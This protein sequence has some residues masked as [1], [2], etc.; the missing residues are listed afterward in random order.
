L[1][2]LEILKKQLAYAEQDEYYSDIFLTAA[3]AVDVI[4]EIVEK[5]ETELEIT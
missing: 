1:A 3:E 4:D 2:V 5:V